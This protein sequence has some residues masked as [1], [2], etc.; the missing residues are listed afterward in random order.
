ME[1]LVAMGAII[2]I[3]IAGA[4]IVDRVEGMRNANEKEK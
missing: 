2:V 4:L 3:L 1:Q